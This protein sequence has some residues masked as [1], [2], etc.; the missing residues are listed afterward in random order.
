M[1]SVTRPSDPLHTWQAP[2]CAKIK[3]VLRL[4]WEMGKSH[5][6]EYPTILGAYAISARCGFRAMMLLSVRI[7]AAEF[8]FS[9]PEPYDW[10][11]SPT[12]RIET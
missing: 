12:A 2:N 1:S 3:E 11:A 4:L 10:P 7:F 5:N 9:Q 8:G 6:T